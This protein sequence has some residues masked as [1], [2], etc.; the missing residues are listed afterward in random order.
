MTPTYSD[1][2]HRLQQF[3]EDHSIDQL[4]RLHPPDS[5]PCRRWGWSAEPSPT[6]FAD[7]HRNSHHCWQLGHSGGNTSEM[8]TIL[9]EMYGKIDRIHNER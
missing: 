5:D 9:L 4:V 2:F 7:L 3:R 8:E 1:K 6:E